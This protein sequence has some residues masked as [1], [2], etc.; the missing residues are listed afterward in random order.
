MKR[1]NEFKQCFPNTS[2]ITQNLQLQRQNS[3]S[4]VRD[5]LLKYKEK[6]PLICELPLDE[7]IIVQYPVSNSQTIGRLTQKYIEINYGWDNRDQYTETA[8]LLDKNGEVWEIKYSASHIINGY[9]HY[10][11]SRIIPKYFDYLL[12][13]GYDIREEVVNLYKID[14]SILQ[15]KKNNFGCTY[16]PYKFLSSN[17]NGTYAFKLNLSSNSSKEKRNSLNKFKIDKIE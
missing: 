9:Y 3:S 11:W 17:G 1:N 6:N 12:L 10:E 14:S 4:K 8:D 13:I 15:D 2:S 16:S 7:F 5:I